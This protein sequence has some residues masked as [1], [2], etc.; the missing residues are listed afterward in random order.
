MEIALYIIIGVVLGAVAVGFFLNRQ[1]SALRL[2]DADKS[3]TLKLKTEELTAKTAKLEQLQQEATELTARCEAQQKEITLLKEQTESETRL[4][5]EQFQQQLRV[6]REQFQN[7]A[8]RVLSQTTD[9]LQLKNRQ[10][11]EA[12]TKPIN[13]NFAELQQAIRDSDKDRASTAASLNE[14]L[15]QMGEQAEKMTGTATKLTNALRGDSK[16]AGDWGELFLNDLLDSQGFKQGIDYDVQGTIVDA[17]GNTV[18]NDDTGRKMRPDVVLHYPGEQDVVID[19]KVSIKAYYDY[20]NEPNENLRNQYLERHVQSLR[21]HVKEL[22]AK[23]YSKYIR[24]PRTTIDFVIM[25]VPNEAAL[26]VALAREPR[27]WNDA[28]EHK[29]FIS[30]T[31]NL[32]AILRMIQIAWR[33]HNQT[34]NQKKIVGL[35][36]QLLGRIG[37][38]VERANKMGRTLET[39]RSDYDDVQKSIT[40]RLSIVQK[41]NELKQLGIAEDKKHPIPKDD[42]DDALPAAE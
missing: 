33:Q 19:A 32:F 21:S 1:L 34:E 42:A 10:S 35:A 41:A 5:A 17:S 22:A 16:Q 39:L 2:T 14:R 18:L 29:V 8:T 40:G 36:E 3:A 6:V 15:R 13:D 38:F 24:P 11:M 25:F 7:L 27:L 37:L 26:Q 9:E 30:S 23:D 28:F 4:R 31:Q 20:V 12:I